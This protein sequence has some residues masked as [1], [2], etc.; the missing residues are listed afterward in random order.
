MG[1]DLFE[2]IA[3]VAPGF[4]GVAAAKFM[5][6]D[7]RTDSATDCL[8]KYFLFAGASWLCTMALA[9]LS[10]Y[11]GLSLTGNSL[12]A[13]SMLIAL[14]LGLLWHDI[15]L[16]KAVKLHNRLNRRLGKNEGFMKNTI[17]EQLLDDCRAHY[18]IAYKGNEVVASGWV[19]TSLAHEKS[20]LLSPSPEWEEWFQKNNIPHR[21]LMYRDEEVYYKEYTLNDE[22]LGNSEIYMK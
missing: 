1:V 12:T 9:K 17:I 13:I 11:T 14:I 2:H 21:F 6:Y 19:T 20:F 15:I 5:D 4:V 8:S 16:P 18:L 3:Q 22:M 10:G 7:T